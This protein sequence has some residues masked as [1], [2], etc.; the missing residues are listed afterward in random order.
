LNLETFPSELITLKALTE[1]ITAILFHVSIQ[2]ISE[3][4]DMVNIYG[5]VATNS[6][7]LRKPV[8][9]KVIS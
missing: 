8:P 6:L 7:A 5:N 4:N 9:T 3:M 2:H 1:V